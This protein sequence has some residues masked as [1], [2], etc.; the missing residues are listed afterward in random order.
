MCDKISE[1]IFTGE[2]DDDQVFFFNVKRNENGK[3]LLQN[4]SSTNHAHIMMS[5]KKLMQNC[6]KEGMFHLDGTYK[7]IKNGFPVLIFGISD[8]QG[9]FHP[10]A[11]C[12]TSNEEEK[13]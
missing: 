6:K 4:G 11:I 13:D 2:E 12:I 3:V 1:N 9:S 10:I 7:L 5:S 8:I